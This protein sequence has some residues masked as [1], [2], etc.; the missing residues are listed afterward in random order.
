MVGCRRRSNGAQVMYVYSTGQKGSEVRRDLLTL[1]FVSVP[2]TSTRLNSSRCCPRLFSGPVGV[3]ARRCLCPHHR[4]SPFSLLCFAFTCDVMAVLRASTLQGRARCVVR[5]PNPPPR[6][7]RG[8]I[9][10]LHVQHGGG[11]IFNACLLPLEITALQQLRACWG[12]HDH[13]YHPRE[14]AR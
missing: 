10:M 6:P 5:Q 9:A 11:R 13:G 4:L 3:S 7:N 12:D 8:I 1:S 2:F 14:R